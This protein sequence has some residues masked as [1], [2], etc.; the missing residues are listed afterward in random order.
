MAGKIKIRSKK[1][2]NFNQWYNEIVF[3]TKLLDHYDISGCYVMLPD[4]C[5]IWELVR[6]YL[7]DQFKRI[8]VK[9]VYFPIL[10]TENNLKR[11]QQHLEGFQVETIWITKN[12]ENK[13]AIRPTSECGIYPTFEKMIR[14]HQD[15]PILFNQWA[16]VVRWEVSQPTPF[17]RSKE[18]LWQEGHCAF[19]NSHYVDM[20]IL[21][22]LEI[23]RKT[24]EKLL[25]VPV[26]V[27]K[28]TKSERF[29]GAIETY[30]LETYIPEAKRS[31]QSATVHDLGQNFSK[32]FNIKFQKENDEH[33]FCYQS[34]WGLTTRSIGVTIM[35]HSD[36]NGL[37]FPPSIAPIQIVIIPI[38]FS[39]EGETNA[40]IQQVSSQLYARLKNNFRVVLDSSEVRPGQKYYYWEAKGVPLRIEIG[41]KDAVNDTC[42]CV[43]RHNSSK[44]I[45]KLDNVG[46]E[47]ISALF[48]SISSDLFAKAS[49]KLD[50]SISFVVTI[51]ELSSSLKL[52]KLPL[53]FLCGDECEGHI[54]D[55]FAIKP[56]C[57]PNMI[58][59]VKFIPND[60]DKFN[61]II[62]SKET[63]TCCL[64][65]K[66]F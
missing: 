3:E 48:E 5:T 40:Q 29:A 46:I 17:I 30:T 33:D 28:K 56:I 41:P 55:K 53:C 15:L 10:I 47:F 36:D 42:V 61:C 58:H 7:D 50:N 45:V 60:K 37:I 49:D 6:Q 14:S 44:N 43:L 27:G 65:S 20:H 23:Y 34:S 35:T 32:M 1:N 62:C 51:N 31:I 22:I 21:D 16:N 2:E 25:C 8:G 18:F 52:G 9:N 38:N 59:Q 12:D 63:K 39:K 13:L 11:E 24:Y 66:T 54:R 57:V 4:S 26:F 19:E 64:V